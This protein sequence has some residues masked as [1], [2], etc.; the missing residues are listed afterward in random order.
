M[1]DQEEGELK[2]LENEL[3]NRNMKIKR[4]KYDLENLKSEKNRLVS[5]LNESKKPPTYASIVVEAREKDVLTYGQH[6]LIT[7]S[8]GNIEKEKVIPGKYVLVGNMPAGI[9]PM[10]SYSTRY[11]QSSAFAIVEI[12][13]RF[14]PLVRAKIASIDFGEDS[15]TVVIRTDPYYTR[16]LIMDK[17]RTIELGLKP[18]L[19]VDCLPETFDIIGVGKVE[20]VAKYEVIERPTTSFDDIGG[21]KEAKRELITS[22]ITPIL[23]P[24]D[25][26][27]YGKTST[28]ILLFGPPGCGKT[29]L[30]RALSHT[31]DNCGFYRI[32]AA[33]IHEM[34]VGKSEE[35]LRNIFKTAVKQLEDKKFNY[36][37]LFFDE[38]DALAPHRGIHPGSSGVEEK[39][40]GELLTWLEGFKPL[41]PNLIVI[42]ATNMPDLVDSAVRQR[43]EKLIEITKPNDKTSVKEIVSKYI[44]RSKVPIDRKML[45]AYGSKAWDVL[46]SEFTD[47]L[48]ED[49]KITSGVSEI[50]KKEIITGRL[51]SQTVENAKELVLYDRTII[52]KKIPPKYKKLFESVDF[53]ERVSKLKSEYKTQKDIGLNICYLKEAFNLNKY[54]RAEEMLSSQMM[55]SIPKKPESRWM[56]MSYYM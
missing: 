33:E 14:A 32:N 20:E 18:N 4:L 11:Q 6:G 1:D 5:L 55:Y 9:P 56:G 8:Y 25:Y 12:L 3:Q 50:G 10:S 30:A 39:V 29:M 27:A 51:I 22:I 37:I 24:K 28:K 35:N 2:K 54:K 15:D 48:F 21:L 53:S 44:C 19:T 47:F 42:A 38:I 36:M 41:P 16:S 43:F 23:N 13:D 34:W 31:L 46:S 26:S 40:V 17:K 7:V 45:D 49:E 52:K